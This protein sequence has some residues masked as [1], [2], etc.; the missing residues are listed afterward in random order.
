MIAHWFGKIPEGAETDILSAH[1]DMLPTLCDVVGIDIPADTDGISL[2]PT[3]IGEKGQ[4]EH[5][6]LYW[7]FPSYGGQQAVRMGKWKGIRENIFKDSL[8][9]KLYNLEEDIRE[10]NDV[11]RRQP[12]IVQRIENI[13]IQEHTVPEIDQFKMKQLK[14]YIVEVNN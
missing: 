14:D 3:L 10:S 8:R 13:F 4:K 6:F 11:S 1:Y 9:V 7:E 5:E 12:E 2:L